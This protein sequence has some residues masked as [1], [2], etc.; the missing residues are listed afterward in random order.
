[1]SVGDVRGLVQCLSWYGGRTECCSADLVN[2]LS[3]SEDLSGSHRT[4]WIVRQYFLFLRSCDNICPSR[5][6]EIIYESFPVILYFSRLAAGGR[7]FWCFQLSHWIPLNLANSCLQFTHRIRLPRKSDAERKTSIYQFSN[8]TQLQFIR[9]LAL[10]KWAC[11]ASRV[12]KCTE[13]IMFLDKQ[14]ALFIETADSLF[15]I[16]KERLKNARFVEF[17]SLSWEI[18]RYSVWTEIYLTTFIE[19]DSS[20]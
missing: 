12:D 16:S 20:Y 11:K 6:L 13:I 19:L 10:V 4:V 2:R 1:M 17:F 15:T 5:M 3:G 9:L 8:R 7:I 18:A 14:A